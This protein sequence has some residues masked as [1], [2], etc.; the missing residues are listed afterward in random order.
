VYNDWFDVTVPQVP[1]LAVVVLGAVVL[2][3][4]GGRLPARGR[5]L[6]QAGLAAL[7]A[8]TIATFGWAVALP[9]LARDYVWTGEDFER[10][11]QL[12]TG[13]NLVIS[14]VTAAGVALLV[15]ALLAARQPRSLGPSG[16]DLRRLAGG[17]QAPGGDPPPDGVGEGERAAAGQDHPVAD[18][19]DDRAGGQL[20]DRDGQRGEHQ[21][22]GEDAA[23]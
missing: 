12:N 2:G 23:A 8:A 16:G 21:V 1:M 3:S 15:A 9:R 6:G 7:L 4:S 14:L 19:V 13:A 10:I 5:T 17:G 11:N 22:G 18:V 20:A